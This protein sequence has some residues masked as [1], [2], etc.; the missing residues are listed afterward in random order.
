MAKDTHDRY[1]SRAGCRLRAGHQTSAGFF[2]DDH[3]PFDW[4]EERVAKLLELNAAGR[5]ALQIAREMG[6]K[7]KSAIIGKLHRLGVAKVRA[8]GSRPRLSGNGPRLNIVTHVRRGAPAKPKG[9]PGG[10]D[11][12]HLALIMAN[13]TPLIPRD[14]K[15]AEIA[16]PRPHANAKPLRDKGAC[17]CAWPLQSTADETD[18]ATLFCCDPVT[19][20]S[21]YCEAHHRRAYSKPKT[22]SSEFV[23][24]L[25]RYA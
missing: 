21:S 3:V 7:S 15:L 13:V 6:A 24:G 4:T 12:G 19:A 10:S 16:D 2:C 18:A 23:R 14:A 20:G 11:R 1:C 9:K 5:S 17:E 22:S 8:A 25:R